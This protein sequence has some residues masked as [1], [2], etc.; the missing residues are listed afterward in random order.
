MKAVWISLTNQYNKEI[1]INMSKYHRIEKNGEFTTLLG[2]DNKYS[3]TVKENL[4][5]I[6]RK[7]SVAVGIDIF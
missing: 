6:K 2:E 7:I 1:L 5:L 3:T 4:Q